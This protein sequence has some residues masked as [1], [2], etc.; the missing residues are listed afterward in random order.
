M[1]DIIMKTMIHVWM[2]NISLDEETFC[3]IIWTFLSGWFKKI[4]ISYGIREKVMKMTLL[5]RS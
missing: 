1:E 2:R 5:H 4:L 3:E